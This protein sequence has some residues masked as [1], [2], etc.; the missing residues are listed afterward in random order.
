MPKIKLI[1]TLFLLFPALFLSA[2]TE[3]FRTVVD[4]VLSISTENTQGSSVNIGINNAVIVNINTNP[5]FL[6]G[7]ELE[8]TA[9]QSW[10]QYQ[11]SLVMMI[12]N[13]LSL[14]SALGVTDLTA[15]RTAFEPLPSRLRIVY[16]IPVRSDHGLRTTTSI[17]VPTGVIQ[18]AGFPIMFRLMQITKGLPDAF[19]Q[20]TFNLT[21]RPI[22]SDEGA[23]KLT[24][25]YPPQLRNRPFIVLINDTV[26]NNINEEIILKEGEHHLVILSDD[27][28]NES[29]RFIVERGRVVE[30]ILDLQDPSPVIIFE[31]PQNSRVFLN[32][33]PIQL[34]REPIT[35]EPGSYEVRFQI[36][37]YTIIRQLNVQRGKTYRVS[38]AVDLTIFEED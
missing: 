31:G 16:H 29:R 19:E 23:V 20:M 8:I 9:P 37:D 34:T 27:Y 2:Q 17:T 24:P 18:P 7:I 15:Y 36:G 33:N 3:S 11:N 12:Y 22:L 14:Q 35:V 21:A 4:G 10:L 13:N 26:I 32:N 5:R 1:L 38:L 30:L 28:R 6:R 25:R